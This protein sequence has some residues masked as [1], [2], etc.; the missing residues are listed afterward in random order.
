MRGPDEAQRWLDQARDDLRWAGHLA[1][2]G[3]YNIACFLSQQSAE[4]AL[5]ALLFHSGEELVIGHAV[6]GL[7]ERAA[8]LVP[9]MREMC[10]RWSFLD[11]FY[12]PTRYP[13][14]LPGGIPAR[15]Y[16]QGAARQAVGLASEVITFVAE[17]VSRSHSA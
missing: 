3:G 1:D 9:D 16:D 8:V 10:A 14:A 11:S 13:D 4:K 15:A 12:L 6:Q 7:C 2:T 5:K 17:H